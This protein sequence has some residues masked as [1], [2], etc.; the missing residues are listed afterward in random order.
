MLTVTITP[1]LEHDA[2]SVHVG[3]DDD[4]GDMVWDSHAPSAIT[5]EARLNLTFPH[6][7]KDGEVITWQAATPQDAELLGWD[8]DTHREVVT[9]GAVLE[10]RPLAEVAEVSGFTERELIDEA[11]AWEAASS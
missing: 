10:N 9:L 5:D 1:C 6:A 3:T 4:T 2:C 11:L 7:V 8:T